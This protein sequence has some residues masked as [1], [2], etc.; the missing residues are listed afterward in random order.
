MDVAQFFHELLVRGNVEVIIMRL[1]KGPL[2]AAQRNRQLESLDGVGETRTP[3]FADQ[4]M[5]VLG[6]D[7]VPR[8]GQKIAAADA[9]QCIL[10]EIPGWR[11]RE[12]GLP[13]ITAEGEDV[14]VS[15]LLI[16]DT[17]ALHGEDESNSASE[18][19][20]RLMGL[21]YPGPAVGLKM[22]IESGPPAS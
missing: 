13:A 8:N 7:D 6:H 1:P 2:P 17:L 16:P 22:Q 11:C 5:D 18:G 12:A 4:Q 19:L 20:A 3:G 10:K 15:R 21:P 9:L 14:K